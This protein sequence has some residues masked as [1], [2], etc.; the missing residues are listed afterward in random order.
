MN[1]FKIAWRHIRKNGFHSFLNIFGL[2]I[3]ILFTILIG[4]FIWSELQVNKTLRQAKAQYLLTSLWKDPNQGNLITT[5]A[6][7]SKRLKEIYPHLV[8]EYY[9]WDGIT[10]VVSKGKSILGKTSS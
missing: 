9:R 1:S 3:G 7:L 4:A 6:P 8:A 5:T 2:S 10:S